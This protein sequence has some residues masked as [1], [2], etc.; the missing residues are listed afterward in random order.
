M[1]RVGFIEKANW[2]KDVKGVRESAMRI[3]RGRVLQARG[4]SGSKGPDVGECLGC[5]GDME[6]PGWLDG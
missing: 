5:A 4:N 2:N 6:E 3:S 1:D